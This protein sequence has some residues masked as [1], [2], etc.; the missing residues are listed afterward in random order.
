MARSFLTVILR[1]TISL[2]TSSAFASEGLFLLPSAPPIVQ[3]LAASVFTIL[4][5]NAEHSW[6]GSAFVVGR[7]PSGLEMLFV[8]TA[9]TLPE[10]CMSAGPC[11]SL[12]LYQDAQFDVKDDRI[13]RVAT[14]GRASRVD[15]VR[16]SV[17][18]DLALLRATFDAPLPLA[19]A[20]PISQA[21]RFQSPLTAFAVGF[22]NVAIRESTAIAM[23]NPDQIVKR[24][25]RGEL[26]AGLYEGATPTSIDGLDGFSGAPVF[27]ESGEVRGVYR[28]IRAEKESG[29][30]YFDSPKADATADDHYA[31]AVSCENLNAFLK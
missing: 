25:A 22:P 12:R 1:A 24:W 7:E 14:S 28:G 3:K 2:V 26:F 21:C 10:N 30:V 23:E 15:V 8:T 18:N 31:T 17:E 16:L 29:F 27:D 11:N 5:E 9:H 13:E 6:R 20:L 19:Q 4:A